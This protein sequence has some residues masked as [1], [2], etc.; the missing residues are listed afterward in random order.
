MKSDAT[1]HGNPDHF[2]DGKYLTRKAKEALIIVLIILFFAQMIG[3][4]F[5]HIFGWQKIP[6]SFFEKNSYDTKLYVYV[7][8]HDHSSRSYKL[9]A[10]ISKGCFDTGGESCTPRLYRLSTFYWENG[11]Y[12]S[13]IDCYVGLQSPN[14]C[15]SEQG[16]D[17]SILM[18]SERVK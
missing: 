16:D 2:K 12:A 17:Y 14:N 10:D 4:G 8:K 7:T 1:Q 11:G 9:A 13:F 5:Q 15:S 6:G 3:G 18:T